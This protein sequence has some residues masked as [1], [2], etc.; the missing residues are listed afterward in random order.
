MK[1]K[2]YVL[3]C[4]NGVKGKGAARASEAALIA[5]CSPMW[6]G[7]RKKYNGFINQDNHESI[8]ALGGAIAA[9]QRQRNGEKVFSEQIPDLLELGTEIGGIF[10]GF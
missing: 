2:L 9:F 5:H 6:D 8:T 1:T 10:E 3:T 4:Q 7:I